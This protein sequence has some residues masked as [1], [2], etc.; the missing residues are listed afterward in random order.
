MTPDVTQWAAKW[1]VSCAALADLAAMIGAQHE[2]ALELT[3]QSEA[4]AQSAIRLEAPRKGVKLFRNNVGALQDQTGRLVRYGL[5]NDTAALNGRLKSGDLIGW[6]SV[7]ITPAHVGRT[8]A[9]FVSRECK[10]PGWKYAGTDRE[11]AQSRWAEMVT[12][13]GGDACFATGEGTL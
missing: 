9:Q 4:Y 10:P 5:A 11:V 13:A 2:A 7:T 3:G 8:I 12:L 6:R 1:G